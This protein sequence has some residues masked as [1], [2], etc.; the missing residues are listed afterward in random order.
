MSRF[1]L[2]NLS[3]QARA[4]VERNRAQQ[5]AQRQQNQRPPPA[6]PETNAII[7]LL[8]LWHLI[9]AIAQLAESEL[10]KSQKITDLNYLRHFIKETFN[11]YSQSEI[12]EAKRKEQ[13]DA[14][15]RRRQAEEAQ[16]LR[17]LDEMKKQQELAEAI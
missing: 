12:D 5:D 17:T 6:A 7:S 13:E 4:Y 15:S 11:L 3:E 8:N 1:R 2:F 16:R 10:A 9:A 14:A